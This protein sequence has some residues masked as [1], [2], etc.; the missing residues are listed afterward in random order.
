MQLT[1]TAKIR[2]YPD[3]QQAAILDQTMR[4]YQAACNYVSEFVYNVSETDYY[5][6]HTQ[7]YGELRSEFG[8][9][10]Q[11]AQSVLKTVAA[12][13]KSLES[14]NHPWTQIEFSVPCADLV[15]GRDYSFP[16]GCVSVGSISG[17]QKMPFNTKGME[18]F[19][20]SKV[21]RFGTAQIVHKKNC[22][23]KSWIKDT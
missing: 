12:R 1:I 11:M 15:Q 14:N 22:K 8:L 16:K 5:A 23:P 13:Y 20:D 10:S 19:F 9:G 7:F 3:E 2:I 21:F 18:R 17:R 4:A 6:L